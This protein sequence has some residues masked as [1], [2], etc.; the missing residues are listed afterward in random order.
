[1]LSLKKSRL[2]KKFVIFGILLSVIPVLFF[3]TFSYINVAKQIN[4]NVN[5]ANQNLLKILRDDVDTKLLSVDQNIYELSILPSTITQLQLSSYKFNWTTFSNI[6]QLKSK[7]DELR[8]LTENSRDMNIEIM[9]IS[10]IGDW[11]IYNSSFYSDKAGA[12]KDK[13]EFAE[14]TLN[15]QAASTSLI[16]SKIAYNDDNIFL[17]RGVY[18]ADGKH[19]GTFLVSIP[20]KDLF[21]RMQELGREEN[22][23]VI[24]SHGNPVI[25]FHPQ[26]DA[27][28]VQ[29][30]LNIYKNE[31][32]TKDNFLCKISN[33]RYSVNATKSKYADWKYVKAA[34]YSPVDDKSLLFGAMLA[35]VAL[36]MLSVAVFAIY[37]FSKKIYKP[38]DAIINSVRLNSSIDDNQ[39]EFEVISNYMTSINDSK[40]LLEGMLDEQRGQIKT[41]FFSNLLRGKLSQAQAETRAQRLELPLYCKW[42]CISHYKIE[43]ISQS[44]FERFDTDLVMFAVKNIAEELLESQSILFCGVFDSDFI[45]FHKI[46]NEN[47]AEVEKY[48]A[49]T[50]QK[51][52]NVITSSLHVQF[53]CGV[54]NV[55]AYLYDAS[56]AYINATDALKYRSRTDEKCIGFYSKM[57]KE[58]QETFIFPKNS[59]NGIKTAISEKN[60]DKAKG[61]LHTFI[62]TLFRQSVGYSEFE[63]SIVKL[64]LNISEYLQE[65]NQS[66]GEGKR[67]Q[68]PEIAGLLS[69]GYSRDVEQWLLDNLLIPVFAEF[70]QERQLSL[71]EQVVKIIKEEYDT[72]LTLEYCASKIG[73][74]SSYVSRVFR[75]QMGY[76]F[77]EYLYLYRIDK[78]KQLLSFTDMKI[79]D[80]SNKLCYNNAQNFIRMFKKVE[81]ITPGEYRLKH[82]NK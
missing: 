61:H 18:T 50:T 4:A 67:L 76:S 43:N 56:E 15:N 62:E 69:L 16:G 46:E 7:M 47:Q 49:Q 79:Q 78:S 39:D 48:I 55:F 30:F 68:T 64:V 20:K 58:Y 33:K 22:F 40:R 19:Y 32:D 80:I 42:F 34:V 21:S 53:G 26:A 25:N 51:L 81:G 38:I 66:R 74:H 29:E 1:M 5:M 82:Q 77:K 70:N 28:P 12:M 13:V 14:A 71:S 27:L 31:I 37:A 45:I 3:S 52:I 2:F 35:T 8:F 60:F 23:I 57:G 63:H 72:P 59:L 11:V 10:E 73:Y 75:Q 24:N 6:N 54:S 9:L 17:V 36:S 41:L 44:D 65:L